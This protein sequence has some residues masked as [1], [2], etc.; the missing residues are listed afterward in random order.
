MTRDAAHAGTNR[1][2]SLVI[3]MQFRASGGPGR[4]QWIGMAGR[5]VNSCV[6]L[7]L[8]LSVI[9]V[10]THRPLFAGKCDIRH[11]S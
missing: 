8:R 1:N 10:K 6:A 5:G 9:C 11:I 2:Y 7:H 4:S 3:M